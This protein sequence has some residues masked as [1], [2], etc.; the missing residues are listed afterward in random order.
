MDLRWSFLEDL[1]LQ[2]AAALDSEGYP[3]TKA[4]RKVRAR[5]LREGKNER[6]RI[7]WIC[8]KYY[9]ARKRKISKARR[10]VLRSPEL[11]AMVLTADQ[12][13][14]LNRI[15]A[16]SK[17]GADLTPYLSTQ[18]TRLSNND[19]LLND[20]G[21]HHLHLGAPAL[22]FV[23]RTGPVLFVR[24]HQMTLLFLTI[25]DHSPGCEP[26]IEEELIE[27]IHR[28]WPE[29]IARYRPPGVVAGSARSP[30]SRSKMREAGLTVLTM[31]KD[32][33]IYVPPGGGYMQSGD[34]TDA[35]RL[36]NRLLTHITELGRQCVDGEDSVNQSIR[37][38]GGDPSQKRLRLGLILGRGIEV[39]D[40]ESSAVVLKSSF[41]W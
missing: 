41:A 30:G 24:V 35:V 1:A 18:I 32:G 3:A 31:T 8:V 22:P 15:E 33:T 19:A 34:S 40:E 38:A 20:W 29:V 39:F 23:K 11:N 7:F 17:A 10:T 2:V 26:W 16:D 14:A 4:L 28:N 36:A 5:L 6:E 12:E 37:Q 13:S 27:I 21:I 25:L 9:S